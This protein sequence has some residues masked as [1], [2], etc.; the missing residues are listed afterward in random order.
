[1][2]D[3]CKSKLGFVNGYVRGSSTDGRTL[4][5]WMERHGKRHIEMELSGDIIDIGWWMSFPSF[6]NVRRW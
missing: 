3:A 1:M 5:P 4:G 6:V 2:E